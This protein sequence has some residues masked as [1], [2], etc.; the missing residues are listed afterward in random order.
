M[1][2][3]E[4]WKKVVDNSNYLVSNK[5][6]VYSKEVIIDTNKTLKKQKH[7]RTYKG[8]ILNFGISMGYF[9]VNLKY[10]NKYYNKKVHWLV[11]ETFIP[12]PDNKPCI[13]HKDGNKL[14]NNVD[15]L[16]W[17][18]YKE[19]TQH[20]IKSGLIEAGE[21]SV[22]S[23]L[24]NKEVIEIKERYKI[25]NISQSKLAKEY[26]VNPSCICNIVNNKTR[27][28]DNIKKINHV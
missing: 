22:T 26:D 5:G 24:T 16:E 27:L 9:K 8:C 17:C 19:N 21:R 20:A 2:E 15:N 4:I 10:N 23:K 25:G 6:R 18:T 12:N 13:N 7:K 14:N 28:F 1:E 11:A 3:K